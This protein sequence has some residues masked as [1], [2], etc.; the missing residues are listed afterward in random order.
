[1]DT[2]RTGCCAYT[3]CITLC[4]AAVIRF[5]YTLKHRRFLR[6]HFVLLNVSVTKLTLR[7]KIYCSMVTFI[8][9]LLRTG[10]ALEMYAPLKVYFITHPKCI[11]VILNLFQNKSRNFWL[12]FL[13]KLNNFTNATQHM[14]RQS[15]SASEEANEIKSLKLKILKGKL[16]DSCRTQLGKK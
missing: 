5:Q 3:A 4:K 16:P 15:T 10:R 14:E 9:Y 6:L 8:F 11:T 1:M 2:V 13:H 12:L 7:T